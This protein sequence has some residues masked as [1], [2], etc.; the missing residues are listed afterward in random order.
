MQNRYSPEFPFSGVPFP[1]NLWKTA[2]VL[3]GFY[4]IFP[5]TGREA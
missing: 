5:R 1:K 2:D 3:F 4:Q